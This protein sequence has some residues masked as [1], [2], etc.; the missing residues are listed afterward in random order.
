MSG[1]NLTILTNLTYFT[2]SYLGLSLFMVNFFSILFIIF[3][4]IFTGFQSSVI[5]AGIMTIVLILAKLIGRIP[6]TRNIL[7]FTVFLI[8]LISPSAL[9]KDLGFQLS[10]LATIGILYLS[11]FFEKI[12]K[13]K[14]IAET[15]SAQIMV[16]PLLWYRFGEFNLFSFLNNALLI[17]FIPFLMVLGFIALL[18]LFFYPINQILNIPFEI[19]SII[20]SFLSKLPKIYL[21]IPLIFVLCIYFY[22]AYLIY[23]INKDGKIDFNFAIN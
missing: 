7:I 18:I 22:L 10:F 14:I 20:L 11:E 21:P 5:R 16:L 23:K 9:V 12:L 2:L 15:V 6:L 4:I 3:F 19:F 1:Y 13:S 8:T 17:P